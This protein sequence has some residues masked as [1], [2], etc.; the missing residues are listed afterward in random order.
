MFK[1]IV[2]ILVLVPVAI[3]LILMSV[4]NRQSATLAFNPFDPSDA[5]MSLTAPFFVF[6][7]MALMIGMVLGSLAT[8]VKQGKHRTRARDNAHEAVKWH[9]EADRQKARAT[10]LAKIPALPAP[11]GTRA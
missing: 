11:D 10:E 7:F 6:L 8:W 9:T 5:V 3:V 2:N 4:A 1:R